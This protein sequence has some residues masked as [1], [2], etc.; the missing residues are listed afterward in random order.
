MIKKMIKKN[1]SYKLSRQLKFKIMVLQKK[2][3]FLEIICVKLKL[4]VEKQA[5][6]Q[7]NVHENYFIKQQNKWLLNQFEFKNQSDIVKK[8]LFWLVM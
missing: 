1:V 6:L 8:S 4:Y 5:F 3:L 2:Y 7:K